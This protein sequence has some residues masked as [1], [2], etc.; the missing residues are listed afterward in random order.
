MRFGILAG[1]ACGAVALL[2]ISIATARAEMP[3]SM[4]SA[5]SPVAQV[6]A[7]NRSCWRRCGRSC[8]GRDRRSACA[9]CMRECESWMLESK[10]S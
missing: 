7:R 2:S 9:V 3:A 10:S 1:F 4:F 5:Q 6:E 8:R